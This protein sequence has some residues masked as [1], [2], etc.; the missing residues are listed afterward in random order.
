[1][2][3]KTNTQNSINFL[4]EQNKNIEDTQPKQNENKIDI[5]KIAEEQKSK[6]MNSKDDGYMKASNVM[7]ANLGAVDDK[8]GPTKQLKTPISNSIWEPNKV[9]SNLNKKDNK[10]ITKAE[11]EDIQKF[12]KQQKEDGMNELVNNLKN[13]DTKKGNSVDLFSTTSEPKSQY[14]SS[15]NNMSI[16]DDTND[17]FE[18]IP[19]K[20]KGEKIAES[21]KERKNKKDKSWQSNQKSL[22]SKDLQNKL[23]DDFFTR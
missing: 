7:S 9:S 8:G 18:N 12:K 21:A 16:F 3:R 13:I 10:E 20:T 6:K 15:P 14:K 2:I 23:F 22:S 1:M 11:K 17:A 5:N 4:S 19:E